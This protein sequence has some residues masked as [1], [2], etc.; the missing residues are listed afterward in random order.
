M[1]KNQNLACVII[2]AGVAGL[3]AACELIDKGITNIVVLEGQDR[4]GGRI[5]TVLRDDVQGIGFF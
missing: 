3:T 4:I 5:H 1:A 2:G